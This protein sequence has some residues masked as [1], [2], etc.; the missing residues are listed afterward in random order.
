MEQ[1]MKFT[2][3]QHV[4]EFVQVPLRDAQAIAAERLL[5]KAGETAL[6]EVVLQPHQLDAVV[7]LRNTLDQLRGALLADDVG[8]GK[9]FVG[10]AVARDYDCAHVLAPAALLPMWRD[11]VRR[12]GSVNVTVHSLHRASHRTGAFPLEPAGRRV[13]VIVD[14]AHHLRTP[15][16]L[17][18]SRVAEFVVGHHVLLI[19]ATPV[20]NTDRDLRALFA[21]FLGSRADLLDEATLEQLVVRRERH[22]VD[23]QRLPRVIERNP[24]SVPLDNDTLEAILALPDPLPA[25]G[26]SVAGALIRLGLLRAWCSSDAALSHSIRLRRLRG[27]AL[28]HALRN[29]RHPTHDELR[30]WVVADTSV[31]LSFVEF[32]EQSVNSTPLLRRLDRHLDALAEL[33]VAHAARSNAD[34]AR[35]LAIRQLLADEPLRPIVAFSQY[36]ATVRALHRALVDIAGVASIS[37]NEARIAS[38]RVSRADVLWRIA[39]R[40]HGRPPPAAHERVRVLIATDLLAEGMNLQEAGT[41]VHLDLPWTDALRRQRVGRCARIGA[42]FDPVLVVTFA[43]PANADRILRISQHLLRKAGIAQRLMGHESQSSHGPPQT[44]SELRQLILTWRITD[45]TAASVIRQSESAVLAF[46]RGA[47]AGWM[48]VVESDGVTRMVARHSGKT[49]DGQRHVLTLVKGLRGPADGPADPDLREIVE[50]T[51]RAELQE[52]IDTNDVD[53]MSGP[54][55]RAVSVAQRALLARL[56]Q[57]VANASAPERAQLAVAATVAERIARASREVAAEKGLELWLSLWTPTVAPRDWL[58]AWRRIPSLQQVGLAMTR[59]AR[60]DKHSPVRIT[61]LMVIEHSA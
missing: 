29:G 42:S 34:E 22:L 57:T 27:E 18:Y 30:A 41:V 32:L 14:E 21:L 61:A 26:G 49:S 16:T 38:G 10:L 28:A 55:Q 40:A 50:Q 46:G 4:S 45:M 51:A 3:Q 8:L 36:T 20:H 58:R 53:A 60:I 44:A 25:R 5:G 7:R 9:T 17:R 1:A 23:T 48:A 56:T 24:V 19:S 54:D 59:M 33:Q 6:G 11:A 37:G 35:A 39:P 31:Q 43:P 12:T 13:L 2:G 15:G 52:W 47:V